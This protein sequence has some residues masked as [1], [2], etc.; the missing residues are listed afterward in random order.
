MTRER[1]RSRETNGSAE[2]WMTREEASCY[3]AHKSGKNGWFGLRLPRYGSKNGLE[4]DD[5]GCSNLCV[6]Q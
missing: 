6:N 2:N 3:R 1:E 5:P 4:L